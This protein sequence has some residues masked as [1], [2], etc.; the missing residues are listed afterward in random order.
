MFCYRYLNIL[1]F[2]WEKVG[3]GL[4]SFF[5]EVRKMYEKEMDILKLFLYGYYNRI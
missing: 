2:R 3:E 1:V 4:G 5:L